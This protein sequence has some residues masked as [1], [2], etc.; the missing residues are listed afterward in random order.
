[1][2]HIKHCHLRS[3]I[4]YSTLSKVE[5]NKLSLTYDKLILLSKGL[6]VDM[7]VLFD[8]ANARNDAHDSLLTT[9]ILHHSDDL[10]IPAGRNSVRR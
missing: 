3:G 5:N 4:S 2:P 6:D 1:M 9:T 7:R 10:P 8:A